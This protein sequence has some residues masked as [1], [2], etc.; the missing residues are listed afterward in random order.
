LQEAE[1]R[2]GKGVTREAQDIFDAFSRTMPARWDGTSIVVADAV[3]I[4]KPYRVDDCRALIA[5]DSAALTRVRKVV[6]TI[7]IAV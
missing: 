2:R 7:C 3:V 6:R 5:N 1:A 4:A